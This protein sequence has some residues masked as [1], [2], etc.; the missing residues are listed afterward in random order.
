MGCA[1]EEAEEN[2][3]DRIGLGGCPFGGVVVVELTFRLARFAVRR[4]I[5]GDRRP[6]AVRSSGMDR[7]KAEN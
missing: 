4:P 2:G 7:L 1:G 3:L 5:K 6:D